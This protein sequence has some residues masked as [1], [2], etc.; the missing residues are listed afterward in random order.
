MRICQQRLQKWWIQKKN[1]RKRQRYENNK[2]QGLVAGY[3][4]VLNKS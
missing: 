1:G 4:R 2:A 3:R